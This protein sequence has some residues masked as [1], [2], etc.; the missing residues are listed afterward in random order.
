MGRTGVRL[1]RQLT[2]EG[3]AFIGAEVR[4][5]SWDGAGGLLTVG[6]GYGKARGSASGASPN[7]P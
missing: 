7:L 6:P 3:G 1:D 2:Q 4:R 5:P